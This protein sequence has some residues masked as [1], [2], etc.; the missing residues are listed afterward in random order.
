MMR[1][2]AMVMYFGFFVICYFLAEEARAK[3]IQ[4]VNE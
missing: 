2:K 4:V 3:Q 1:Q